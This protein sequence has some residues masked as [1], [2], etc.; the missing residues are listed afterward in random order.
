MAGRAG[1]AW[2]AEQKNKKQPTYTAMTTMTFWNATS[3]LVLAREVTPPLKQNNVL[4]VEDQQ[5]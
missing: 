2:Q 4:V 5:K 3:Y 1:K